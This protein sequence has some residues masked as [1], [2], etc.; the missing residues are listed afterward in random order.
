MQKIITDD[1]VE[2]KALELRR[3]YQRQRYQIHKEKMRERQKE[4]WI[5]KAKEVLEEEKQEDLMQ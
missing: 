4:F 2:Q 1:A 5:K 3:E